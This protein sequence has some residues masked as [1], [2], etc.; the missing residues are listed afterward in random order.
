MLIVRFDSVDVCG[1]VLVM[2]HA[3]GCGPTWR[4]LSTDFT[5]CWPGPDEK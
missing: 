3:L 4:D 5:T 2:A 1:L